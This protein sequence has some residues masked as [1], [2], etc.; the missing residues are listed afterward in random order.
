MSGL[1]GEYAQFYDALYADKNYAAEAGYFFSL[2]NKYQTFDVKKI[3]EFGAGTGKH[4]LE[5]KKLGFEAQGVELSKEMCALAEVAGAQVLEGDFRSYQHHEKVDAVLALFHVVSYLAE[6]EDL[7][8]G[9]RNAASHLALGGLFVFD[10]WFEG[11]VINEGPSVRVK[12][13]ISRDL[14]VFRIGE[15]QM[16]AQA[17]AVEVEYTIFAKETGG[18]F[19][20]QST[21]SHRMRYFSL[22]ELES[23]LQDTG[24][25]M[26]QA[27]ESFT[28]R[29]LT[30]TS[31]SVTVVAKLNE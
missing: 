12:R 18:E 14:T 5:F 24:F 2:I 13:G 1:F 17:R 19:W 28:G 10:V 21:E 7:V 29:E 23:A 8:S 11:G 20:V 4:Q 3:L 15:P 22:A 25:V 26:V 30:D 31:W 6:K 9:F 16:D 27:E